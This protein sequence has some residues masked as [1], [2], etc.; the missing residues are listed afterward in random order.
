MLKIWGR[1]TSSNVQAVMWTVGELEIPFERYDVGHR[2]G[3]NNTPEYLSM[4]PNGLVP[5]V[6]DGDDGEPLF[7][8]AAICRYLAARYGN[9]DFWPQDPA[10]RAHVDKWAEWGKVTVA[11]AFTMPIFGPLIRLPKEERDAEQ[12]ANAVTT[13]DR[14]LGIADAELEKS[15]LPCRQPADARRYHAR[16]PAIPILHD[17]NRPAFTPRR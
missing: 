2:F 10:R 9:D 15:P 11:A 5:V 16:S 4:N 6:R 12:I 1:R 8:S 17:R 3:G 7:E 13:F 14:L